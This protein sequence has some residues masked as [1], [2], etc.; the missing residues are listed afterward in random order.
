MGGAQSPFKTN[1]NGT[2][3]PEMLQLEVAANDSIYIYVVVTIDPTQNNLPFLVTD[4][5]E[6]KFNNQT[7]Y[8]Q[9]EAYGQNAN[10]ITHQTINSTQ[11]WNHPL[12]FVVLGSLT[13]RETGQLTLSPGTRMYVRATAPIIIQGTLITN[14]TRNRP[15]VFRGERIDEYYRDLPGSWPGIVFTETSKNNVL[16]FT[17]LHN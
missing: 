11:V 9:L 10:F 5:I 8:I 14:G 7:R 15:V 17:E 6:I 1:I 13:V 4:S 12:P 16:T 2:P 3:T